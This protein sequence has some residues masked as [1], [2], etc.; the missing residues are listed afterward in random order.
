ME[1]QNENQRARSCR[2]IVRHLAA[3]STMRDCPSVRNS[4]PTRSSLDRGCVTWVLKAEIGGRDNESD[5]EGDDDSLYRQRY[6][7]LSIP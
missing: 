6:E 7:V 5:N 2:R 1:P 3:V 4:L